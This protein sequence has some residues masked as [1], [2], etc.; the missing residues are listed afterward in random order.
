MCAHEESLRSQEAWPAASKSLLTGI[1]KQWVC[2][3]ALGSEDRWMSAI[4]AINL[5]HLPTEVLGITTRA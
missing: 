3:D 4:S 2:E 5:F 1:M